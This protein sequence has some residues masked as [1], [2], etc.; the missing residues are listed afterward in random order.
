VL[1]GDPS[2]NAVQPSAVCAF[3]LN[4]ERSFG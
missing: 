2:R 1:I 4:S 3:G